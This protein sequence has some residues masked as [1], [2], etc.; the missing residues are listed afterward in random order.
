[1]AEIIKIVLTGGPCGGKT[2]ALGFLQKE[3][4]DRGVAVAC[5][6]EAASMVKRMIRDGKLPDDMSSFA[7]HHM[8]FLYYQLQLLKYLNHMLLH[9]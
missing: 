1:M 2:G 5:A 8:L 3:L 9:K 7:F 4:T 6:E